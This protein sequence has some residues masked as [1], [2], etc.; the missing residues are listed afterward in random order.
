M[1]E[2]GTKDAVELVVHQGHQLQLDPTTEL[3]YVLFFRVCC[4]YI[5][6][7]NTMVVYVM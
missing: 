4:I 2:R 6:T 1:E 3:V 7:P 5:S